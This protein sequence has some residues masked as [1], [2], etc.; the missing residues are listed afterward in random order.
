MSTRRGFTLVELLVVI[1]IIAVLVSIL[2]PSLGKARASAQSAAC[3]SNLRQIGLGI[4][5]YANDNQ[6]QL[7]PAHLDWDLWDNNL[8]TGAKAPDSWAGLLRAGK[9]LSFSIANGPGSGAVTSGNVLYCSSAQPTVSESLYG[10]PADGQGWRHYSDRNSKPG[11]DAQIDNW[12]AINTLGYYDATQF[13]TSAGV[14]RPHER[15]P[16]RS[17]NRQAFLDGN[18]K[19]VKLSNIKQTSEVAAVYDGRG[20]HYDDPIAAMR[21]FRHR[22]G[23]VNVAF[24]DG[25]AAPADFTTVP[26]TNI[27]SSLQRMWFEDFHTEV[28]NKTGVRFR[29]DIR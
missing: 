1:G 25:H 14:S 16:F 26:R 23:V 18:A 7:V 19:L 29:V 15:Y 6:G 2:L 22:N 5:L 28:R 24:L 13:A 17:Y 27:G 9:Y 11:L 3:L 10:W 4:V 12:Y 21:P 20:V 8:P